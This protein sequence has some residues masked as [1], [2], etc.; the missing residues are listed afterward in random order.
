MELTE[1]KRGADVE[2]PTE[3]TELK[4][5]FVEHKKYVKPSEK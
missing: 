4:L 1:E 3:I 2:L 5:S